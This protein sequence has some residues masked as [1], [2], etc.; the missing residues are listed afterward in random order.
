M[1]SLKFELKK[2]SALT[3][4]EIQAW[5]ELITKYDFNKRAFLSPDFCNAVA[6]H[7]PQIRVIVFR[8]T[9]DLVGFMP[10][11]AGSGL[12]KLGG[13]FE[14]VGGT[15][16][17]YFGLVA[18]PGFTVNIED[19]LKRIK[20]NAILFTHLDDSQV[21]FGLMGS[22]PRIGLRTLISGTGSDHWEQLRAIDKKLVSDTER[23][24]RKLIAEHGLL[25]FEF[26]STTP[27]VDL[28][29]LINLKQAQYV[30][31]GKT[32]APLFQETNLALLRSLIH[33]NDESCSGILSVLRINGELVAGHFG[34]RCYGTLHF[35]FPVYAIQYNAYSPGRILLKYIL[36]EATSLGIHT[37]D[38]GEGDN[39]AKR[40]FANNEHFYYRGAWLRPG[41]GGVIAKY[42][43]SIMWRY[44][45]LMQ[46]L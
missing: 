31:T 23:R 14:P 25:D 40:D 21:E 22:Q 10:I 43:M 2:Y 33:A 12:L 11:Q 38:R 28:D 13:I 45:A 29:L 9:N 27:E 19:V 41:L 24:E 18:E 32:D 3:K 7:R 42:V 17:D 6:S 4:T 15:M 8:S 46:R 5:R 39:Q 36:H 1:N 16:A 20:I 34:L 30:R 44:N 35:W 37:I 26:S